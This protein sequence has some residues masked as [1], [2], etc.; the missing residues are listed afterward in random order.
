MR[1]SVLSAG[2]QQM[3]DAICSGV[4]YLRA[5]MKGDCPL[6]PHFFFFFQYWV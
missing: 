1:E 5:F 6:S 3:T 4:A 2:F